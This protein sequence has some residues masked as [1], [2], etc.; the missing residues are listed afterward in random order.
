MKAVNGLSLFEMTFL[1]CVG[2]R[3]SIKH[4]FILCK[5]VVYHCGGGDPFT[6]MI[7]NVS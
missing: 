2:G 7:N 4:Q 1:M 6:Q 3:L 5:C